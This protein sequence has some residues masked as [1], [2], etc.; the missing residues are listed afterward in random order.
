MSLAIEIALL[1]IQVGLFVGAAIFLYRTFV[2]VIS[3]HLD[4]PF[5]PTPVRYADLV[6]GAL[7]IRAGDVVYELGSG[8]GRFMLACAAHA[9]E[10][11][12]VGIERN[13]LL[14]GMALAR[15]RS[16]RSTNVE[17]RRGDLFKTDLSNA[18]KVYAYLLDSVMFKL[19]PKFESEFRGIVASR[20]F[21]F[22]RKPLSNVVAL[23]ETI[24]AHGQHLLFIYDF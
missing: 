14:H 5:V 15:K 2:W 13:P 8:D 21:P 19:Q 17:F 12:F 20:A 9:P 1:C 4:V 23:T 24:G 18:T 6:I 10:A 7:D 22:P 16:A 3:G 11:R